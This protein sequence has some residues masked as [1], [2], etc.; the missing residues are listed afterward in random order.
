EPTEAAP[1]KT[2]GVKRAPTDDPA[3]PGP[4]PPKAADQPTKRSGQVAVFVSRKEQ[5]IFV[6]QGFVPLFDMPIVIEQP[7][8]PL[9]TH[10]FTAMEVTDNGSG[11]R[12]NLISIPSEPA[13]STEERDTRKKSNEAP[14]VPALG[15]RRKRS[16]ASR[17]RGRRPTVSTK[18]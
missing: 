14:A 11:M 1:S 16:T 10:V 8:Q 2:D 3:K 13:V 15:P 5:K 12:W 4:P 17:F 6:R 7:D 18:S 9:G